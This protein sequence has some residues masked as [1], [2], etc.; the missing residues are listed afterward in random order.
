MLNTVAQAVQPEDVVSA[1][2]RTT[3]LSGIDAKSG[4]NIVEHPTETQ[5]PADRLGKLALLL[6]IAIT[7]VLGRL[8]RAPYGLRCRLDREIEENNG[9]HHPGPGRVSRRLPA[10]KQPTSD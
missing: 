9:D 5:V 6:E 8:V 2:Q 4:Q 3:F 10:I 7:P 1:R